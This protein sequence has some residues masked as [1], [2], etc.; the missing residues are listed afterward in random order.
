MKNTI[1]ALMAAL[2]LPCGVSVEAARPKKSAHKTSVKASAKK[3]S[4]ARI[5][6]L[7]AVGSTANKNTEKAQDSVIE[8]P[9]LADN[10]VANSGNVSGETI[11]KTAMQYIGVPYRHGTSSPKS[12]DCSGFT[13]YV[14]RQFDITLSRCSSAQY[15]Q[16][17]IIRDKS[18]LRAGDL[19]FFKGRS[20]R[21]GVGHVGIVIEANPSDKSFK[22]VHA[23]NRGVG[24]DDSKMAYYSSRYV[25]ARRILSDDS[26][27]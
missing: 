7:K 17:R 23:R 27:D 24:I 1:I 22:F 19:V 26:E 8:T 21:G 10:E 13:S 15:A 25:G 6:R 12:F 9:M 3:R 11:V 4:A 14:Y 5:A 20:G 2:M 16:G 18:Q